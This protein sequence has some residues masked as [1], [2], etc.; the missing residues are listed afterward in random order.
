MSVISAQHQNETVKTAEDVRREKFRGSLFV[1]VGVTR[2]T[3][4]LGYLETRITRRR[5]RGSGSR[6]ELAKRLEQVLN[7]R[8]N[9]RW[10]RA[11]KGQR[12]PTTSQSADMLRQIEDAVAA[13]NGRCRERVVDADDVIYTVMTAIRN[14]SGYSDGGTVKA[15]SYGYR[16]TTTAIRCLRNADGTVTAVISRDGRKR[17]LTF[18]AK[19][20]ETL[21]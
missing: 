11:R 7:R 19:W 9:Q 20:W 10:E 5:P 1:K 15:S 3:E 2:C 13:V 14:G 8:A 6:R 4:T 17:S 18:V 12:K 16:W 21:A